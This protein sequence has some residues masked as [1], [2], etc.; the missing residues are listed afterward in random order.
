MADVAATLL[1]NGQLLTAVHAS[2]VYQKLMQIASGAVYTNLLDPDNDNPHVVL[3][4]GRY[5]LV[6]D[7]AEARKQCIVAFNWRHQRLGLERAADKRGRK[8][9]VI[10]GTVPDKLRIEAVDLFQA[11]E[12]DDIYAHPQSGGHG[13]TL[14]KGTTTIW[15][16]PTYNAEFYKQLNHRIYRAGQTM[17]T[18]TI[19]IIARNTC[20][21]QVYSKLGKKLTSMQLLL[22]LLQS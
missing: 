22:D 11:G 15:T 8:Y 13:L 4:D 16:S 7:L 21:E 17:K 12:I 6:M 18:E 10:D 20:D 1:A 9:R 5:E 14:T 3:D 2:S 19:H